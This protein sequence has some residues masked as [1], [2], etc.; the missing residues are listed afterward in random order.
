MNVRQ[1][2]VSGI[3]NASCRT[4]N[5]KAVSVHCDAFR[6]ALP[7]FYVIVFEHSLSLI[8][9]PKQ[10][11]ETRCVMQDNKSLSSHVVSHRNVVEQSGNIDLECQ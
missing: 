10:E 9:L 8:L 2:C 1:C 5:F 3:K 4:G 11:M 6:E 7:L